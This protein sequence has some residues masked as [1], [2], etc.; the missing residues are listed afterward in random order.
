M[1]IV[2]ILAVTGNLAGA[3][4]ALDSAIAAN[5]ENSPLRQLGATLQQ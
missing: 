3:R 2:R 1:M 5:P 4:Q